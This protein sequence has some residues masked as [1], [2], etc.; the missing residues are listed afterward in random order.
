MIAI[1]TN[2]KAQQT[3]TIKYKRIDSN[4]NKKLEK[5]VMVDVFYNVFG[6]PSVEKTIG[7]YH[8]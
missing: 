8:V 4:E 7:L 5:V 1:H 2:Y 6:T 3:K